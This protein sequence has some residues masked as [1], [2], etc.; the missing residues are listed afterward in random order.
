VNLVLGPM[1]GS[2]FIVPLPELLRDA[3]EYQLLVYGVCL[4]V[5]VVF[6]KQGLVSLFQSPKKGVRA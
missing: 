4:M 1:L 5:F 3:R 2:L 6:L